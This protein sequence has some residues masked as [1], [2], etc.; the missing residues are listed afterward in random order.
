MRYYFHFIRLQTIVVQRAI[1]L[2]ITT[3]FC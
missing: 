1:E 3:Q 2:W